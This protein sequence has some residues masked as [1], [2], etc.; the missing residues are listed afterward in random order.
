MLRR[1]KF[2]LSLA[3]LL[4][5]GLALNA[6]TLRGKPGAGTT[7]KIKFDLGKNIH[8]TAQASGAPRFQK[9]ETAGLVDYSIAA[10]LDTVPAHYTRAGYEIVWSPIFAFTMYADR[11]QGADLRV[12]TVH[13]QLDNKIKTHEEAQAF[14]EQTLAQFQKGKWQRYYNPVWDTLLTGRSSFLNEK[15]EIRGV[16]MA[17]DPAYKIL[18]TEWPVLVKK[19]PTWRWVGDGVL[20][21]LEVSELGNAERGLDYRMNLEFELLDIK[22]KVD[23][24]NEAREL[25]QG[26]AK[27][28][29]ITARL[30]R[31]KKERAEL[32]K[33][34]EA[35]AIQR[36]DSVVTKP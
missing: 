33:R 2:L 4:V 17:I 26:D 23:A 31:E 15:G 34:L 27:G 35:N 18:P 28:W 29:N 1:R 30:E 36:G 13:L 3:A 6:M 22:L 25:K 19:N 5:G 9:S 20:A 21:S 11:D 8:D 12:Q 32:N 10:V 16:P 7:P 24:E 14:V